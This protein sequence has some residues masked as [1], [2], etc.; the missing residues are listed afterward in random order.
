MCQ[1]F[2]H[3]VEDWASQY[4][5]RLAGHISSSHAARMTCTTVHLRHM[6]QKKGVYQL[7]AYNLNFSAHKGLQ[8][9]GLG[10]MFALLWHL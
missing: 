4:E 3:S 5:C 7:K 9:G 2:P 8:R 1:V 6:I 10:T